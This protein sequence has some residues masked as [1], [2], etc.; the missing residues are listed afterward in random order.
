MSTKEISIQEIQSEVAKEL[1]NKEVLATLVATT[2]NGLQPAMVK[3]AIVEG[4]MRGFT[5]KDFLEK[6]VYAIPYGAKYSLVSSIDHARKIGMRS[7]I[8]GKSEP[9]YEMDAEGKKIVACSI[10]VK[11]KVGD[12]IGD[13]TA[14][15]YFAEYST[16]KNQWGTKPRTM[17][18]KVAEMHALRMAC[19]EE[20]SQ[21]YAQEELEV[22][23]E[24]K[25]MDPID[26]EAYAKKLRSCV[27][28]A[29]LQREWSAIPYEAKQKL[30]AVKNEAKSILK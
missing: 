14:K 26:V 7:G 18:A 8:V 3:Q 28:L 29:D 4:M 12:Y 27:T 6:N 30:E 2:F 10:T 21:M 25:E 1:S 5:F 23:V 13:F 17:I 22:A 19:P 11:K 20:M 9:V 24:P 15:V 16:G